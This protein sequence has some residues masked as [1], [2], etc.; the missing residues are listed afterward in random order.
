MT[1]QMPRLTTQ[2][3]LNNPPP[4]ASFVLLPI[5]QK[6]HITVPLTYLAR[7]AVAATTKYGVS[8]LR[9]N[10]SIM[11]LCSKDNLL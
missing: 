10:T 1:V 3:R 7:A 4:V 5:R 8:G 9:G 2:R 6:H 11:E